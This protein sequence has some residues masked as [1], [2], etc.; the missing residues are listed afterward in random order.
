MPVRKINDCEMKSINDVSKEIGMSQA[1]IRK[2]L[3]RGLISTTKTKQESLKYGWYDETAIFRLRLI[4]MFR[5]LDVS[6]DEIQ[7]TFENPNLDHNA[8]LDQLITRLQKRRDEITRQIEFCELA[9]FSGL[10]GMALIAASSGS[11]DSY[12]VQY[13]EL[14]QGLIPQIEANADDELWDVGIIQKLGQFH[15]ISAYAPTSDEAQAYMDGLI[16][17]FEKLCL[18]FMIGKSTAA[19]CGTRIVALFMLGYLLL[20]EGMLADIVREKAGK[21][22]KDYIIRAAV[23]CTFRTLENLCT[24]LRVEYARC[25]SDDS[26]QDYLYTARSRF[27]KWISVISPHTDLESDDDILEMVKDFAESESGTFCDPDES[28]ELYQEIVKAWNKLPL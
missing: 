16:G 17:D 14:M 28:D 21:D 9:K 27:S 8:L 11:I 13:K 19:D 18:G 26:K 23:Y 6:L 1:N 7:A 4:K 12:M 15:D 10:K 5:E 2:Y 3:E 22:A 20:S 25:K 24:V